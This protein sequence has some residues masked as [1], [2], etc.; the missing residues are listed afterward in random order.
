MLYQ[1]LIVCLVIL[2]LCVG[3]YIGLGWAKNL[4]DNTDT[5]KCW[6]PV[7]MFIALMLIFFW[8]PIYIIAFIVKLVMLIF[9]KKTPNN[10]KLIS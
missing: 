3:V 4:S 8:L 2:Y 7:V 9:S 6:L 10:K 5:K 1:F